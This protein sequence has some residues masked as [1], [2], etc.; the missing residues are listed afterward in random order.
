[1]ESCESSRKKSIHLFGPGCLKIASAQSSF[2]VSDRDA[3]IEA[4]Q[5]SSE[6]CCC[7]AVYKDKIW[8][9]HFNNSGNSIEYGGCNTSQRLVG[10]HQ[11][12]I[13]IGLDTK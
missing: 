10:A 5:R 12:Q 11:V 3:A 4:S 9:A 8:I 1:M 6:G 2:Y 7:I 13:E